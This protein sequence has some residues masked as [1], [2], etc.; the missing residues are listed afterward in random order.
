[1]AWSHDLPS[2]T[3]GEVTD[4]I[5]AAASVGPRAVTAGRSAALVAARRV[6]IHSVTVEATQWP[7][8]RPKTEIASQ[9][10]ACS[11]MHARWGLDRRKIG[12]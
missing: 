7:N 4:A 10:A 3:F 11:P 1:M 5:R 12:R 6:G 2:L 8:M 9:A